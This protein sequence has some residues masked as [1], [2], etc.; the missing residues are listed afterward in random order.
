MKY[1]SGWVHCKFRDLDCQCESTKTKKNKEK[2]H[3]TKSHSRV[4]QL[5]FFK[6]FF[7]LNSLSYTAYR[8]FCETDG[9]NSEFFFFFTF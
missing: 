6:T 4:M 7:F 2:K 8:A 5:L 3:T 9:I 1:L